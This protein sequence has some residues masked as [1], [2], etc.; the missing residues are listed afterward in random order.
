M[1]KA[2]MHHVLFFFLFYINNKKGCTNRTTFL[3]H[4]LYVYR[5][6]FV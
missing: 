4:L 3:K 2:S 1:E 6:E 5:F